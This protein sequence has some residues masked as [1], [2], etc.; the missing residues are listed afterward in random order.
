[1]I[2]ADEIK[3]LLNKGENIFVDFKA[4]KY[5]DKDQIDIAIDI[6]AFANRHG[7]K[8]LIG[9]CDNT[10]PEKC[11][12]SYECIDDIKNRF[13][14]I[15]NDKCSPKVNLEVYKIP[16][17]GSD[18]IVVDIDK[19]KG[20]PHAVLGKN[21]QGIIISRNYYIRTDNSNRLVD[22]TTLKFLF[23]SLNDPNLKFYTNFIVWITKEKTPYTA[24]GFILKYEHYV[25]QFLDIIKDKLDFNI[26]NENLTKTLIGIMPYA[27]LN[28]LASIFR[29]S[30]LIDSR[31]HIGYI[32]ISPLITNLNSNT[33]KISDIKYNKMEPMLNY[34]NI[35]K[36]L[37]NIN[38]IQV[39][40]ETSI[41][42]EF[43]ENKLSSKIKIVNPH[44]TIEIIFSCSMALTGIPTDIQMIHPNE[45]YEHFLPFYFTIDFNA[46]FKFPDIQDPLFEKHDRFI[47]II[48]NSIKEDWNW[49]KIKDT[50]YEEKIN[51][52][53]L[54]VLKILS[55]NK[56]QK[57]SV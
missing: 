45:N 36:I 44:F 6:T 21:N 52:I 28:Y 25:Y 30:W 47:K 26:N 22:D 11:T 9:V 17:D 55:S 27:F 53:N 54:N 23:N 38:P 32:S 33:I 50:F 42:I 2:S 49:S 43:D 56:N 29:H 14:N 1:M 46:T 15:S 57:N 7:G 8:I 5:T 31:D 16:V 20:I 35:K 13:G 24:P 48:T 34:G 18:I 39:P 12:F 10:K 37:E 19:R 51:N 40:P 3:E 41:E 4:S